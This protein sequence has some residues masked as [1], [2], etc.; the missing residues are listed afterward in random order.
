MVTLTKARS[1]LGADCSMTDEEIAAMLDQFRRI[2]S[3]ALDATDRRRGDGRGSE[4]RP[5]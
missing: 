5:R 4:S 1:V 3:L 2:A